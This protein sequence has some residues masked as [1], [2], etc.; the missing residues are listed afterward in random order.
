[1]GVQ[2]GRAIPRNRMLFKLSVQR[3][4]ITDIRCF[5]YNET[6]ND[7][8]GTGEIDKKKHEIKHEKGGKTTVTDVVVSTLSYHF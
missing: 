1:M 6:I 3:L 7:L 5:Q 2:D 8:L 4:L